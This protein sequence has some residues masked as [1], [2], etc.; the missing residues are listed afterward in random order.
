M[1]GGARATRVSFFLGWLLF[2]LRIYAAPVDQLCLAVRLFYS[3]FDKLPLAVQL[4]VSPTILCLS[5]C[6]TDTLAACFASLSI[7]VPVSIEEQASSYNTAITEF[8]LGGW[9]L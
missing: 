5:N 7:V 6:P 3:F 4:P 8:A 9:K 2:V 1:R